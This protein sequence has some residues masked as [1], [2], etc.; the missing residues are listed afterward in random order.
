LGEDSNASLGSGGIAV[1]EVIIWLSL[2]S[3]SDASLSSSVIAVDEI[4]IWL[5]SNGNTSLGSGVIA[6]NEIIIWLRFLSVHGI[7][8]GVGDSLE[9]GSSSVLHVDLGGGIVPFLGV[10]SKD[11]ISVVLGNHLVVLQLEF[12]LSGGSG[13]GGISGGLPGS[14]R[15][16]WGSNELVMVVVSSFDSGQ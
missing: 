6:M 8:L 2:L 10:G 13:S 11:I 15:F 1:D 16:I 5:L 7:E 4:I 3:N 14:S 12:L 9:W